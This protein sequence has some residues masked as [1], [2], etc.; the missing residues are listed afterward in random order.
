MVHDITPEALQARLQSGESLVVIDVREAHEL[1]I[2]SLPFAH[3]IPMGDIPTR[4]SEI[5]PAATTVVMSAEPWARSIRKPSPEVEPMSSATSA[6]FQA[7][8]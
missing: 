4:L 1:E 3:H 2:S 5:D 8:P 7:T 6:I